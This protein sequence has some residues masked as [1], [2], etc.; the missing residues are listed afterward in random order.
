V[1][2]IANREGASIDGKRLRDRASI[3]L[4]AH[5]AGLKANQHPRART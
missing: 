1:K 2:G 5:L 3:P 4:K